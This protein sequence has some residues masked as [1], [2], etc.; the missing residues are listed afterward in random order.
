MTSRRHFLAAMASLPLAASPLGVFAQSPARRLGMPPL[1]DARDSGVFRL[2]AQAGQTNFTG[3]GASTTWGLNGAYL[4]PTVRLA[5]GRTSRAEVANGLNE[6]ITLHWHGLV[7]P[8]EVDGSPHQPIAPATTWS[9]ELPVDQPA[10]TAWYHSHFHGATARQV[11]LGLAGVLQVDDGQDDAR[12]LPSDYGVDDLTLVL[13]DRRFTR[14]GQMDYNLSMSEGMSGFMGDTMVVNGQVG[15]TAVVPRGLVRLRLLNG[16]N[17]RIYPLSFNDRR[18]MHL[19][20]TDSGYLDRPIALKTL[21]LAPGERAEVLV[22]FSDGVE[23]GLVSA[24][25]PNAAKGGMM[26]GGGGGRPFVVLPFTFDTSLPARITQI[27]QDLGGEL[28]LRNGANIP[29]RR[30][31][32]DMPMGAGMMFGSSDAFGVNGRPFDRGRIDFA[33]GR[34]NVERWRISA[35][36]MMHPFHIHG[37][38]FAVLSENGR[39]PFAQNLGWK[40]TV[41]VNGQVE[42]LVRFDQP[43]PRNAPFMYHCHILEHEDRGMMGQFAVS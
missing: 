2:A 12:G 17:A 28:P 13:Q 26:G 25:N 22:D 8:G 1:L 20:A 5:T 33:I 16:S 43:A 7:I 35:D 34:G 4:G 36:L 14:R 19:V 41:L 18:D 32:L 40:D 31:N 29:V 23:S 3:R 11:Q 38:R 42:L 6:A 37:V 9:P 21:V 30:L 10:C 24:Q 27:P 15:A 39:A